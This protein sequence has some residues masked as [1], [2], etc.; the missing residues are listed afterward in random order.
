M[1]DIA[2]YRFGVW[3]WGLLTFIG[4]IG[5]LFV[6]IASAFHL[7]GDS[8]FDSSMDGGTL[9]GFFYAIKS[10]ASLLGGL[11]GFGGLAWSQ[12]FI[13]LREREKVER[14]A[15]AARAEQQ[16]QASAAVVSPPVKPE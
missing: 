3:G 13:A 12:F 15:A 5:C 8:K 7:V 14:D 2:I 11:I 6:L 16:R 4:A 9:A 1:S 10:S